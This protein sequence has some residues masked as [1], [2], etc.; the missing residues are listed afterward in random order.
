MP[1]RAAAADVTGSTP[2]CPRSAQLKAAVIRQQLRRIAGIDR[3]V[4]VEP[5]PGDADGLGWRTRVKFAV[6][7][8]GTA[9]LRR[10]RSHQVAAIGVCPIAHQLV[11]A[12]GV[13]RG[14]WPGARSVEVAV[15]P[16]LGRARGYRLR[17]YLPFQIMA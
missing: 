17:W 16:G 1:G 5:L 15:A 10:H 6:R 7:P 8:D 14:R 4:L 12:V 11:T 2:A 9:G 3:D 13:T